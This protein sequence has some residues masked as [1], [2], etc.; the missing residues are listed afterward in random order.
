MEDFFDSPSKELR[1]RKSEWKARVIAASLNCIHSLARHAQL[2]G[3]IALR[4]AA[5]RTQIWDR[6]RHFPIA[7]SLSICTTKTAQ[8]T[9]DIHAVLKWGSPRSSK[10]K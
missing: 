2:L 3:E 10:K 8:T 5:L 7:M 4:P 1:N 6:I 9:F